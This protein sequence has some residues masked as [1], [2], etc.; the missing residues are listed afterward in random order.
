MNDAE[1]D[2]LLEGALTGPG[3][4]EALRKQALRESLASL[5]HQRQKRT[6]WRLAGLAAAAVV[7]AA[8]SFLLGRCSAPSRETG[9]P[10]V[11]TH[12][13]GAGQTVAVPGEVVAWLEAARF[14][15]QL[16]M[17]ERVARAYERAS[18]LLPQEAAMAGGAMGPAFAADSRAMERGRK[19]AGPVDVSGPR[20]SVVNMGRIMAQS[21]GE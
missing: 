17:E 5:A 10:P 7:I 21:F 16:G 19:R 12:A 2:K 9:V 8:V 15:K 18:A 20:P 6:R 1:V 4:Q 14:F 13:V 3:P 11:A